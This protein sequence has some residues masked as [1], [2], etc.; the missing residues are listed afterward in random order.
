MQVLIDLPD[1]LRNI[2]FAGF[3]SGIVSGTTTT[4]FTSVVGITA[5]GTSLTG[6]ST[7][8][9]FSFLHEVTANMARPMMT[10]TAMRFMIDSLKSRAGGLVQLCLVAWLL[11][12]WGRTGN[13]FQVALVGR[14]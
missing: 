3:G 6:A 1:V 4:G 14:F 5:V 12:P 10:M 11:H 8:T 9:C 7:L 2:H 13:F